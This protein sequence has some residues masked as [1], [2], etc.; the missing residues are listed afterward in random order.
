MRKLDRNEFIARVNRTREAR[1]LSW[2]ELATRIGSLSSV[3]RWRTAQGWPRLEAIAVVSETLGVTVDYLLFG[4]SLGPASSAAAWEAIHTIPRQHRQ[5]LCA[6]LLGDLPGTGADDEAG[7]PLEHRLR[8]G[9]PE[10]L[11][12]VHAEQP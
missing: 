1:G 5:A 2:K 8:C 10:P 12:V 3:R 11:G 7:D 9:D 6:I 4:E